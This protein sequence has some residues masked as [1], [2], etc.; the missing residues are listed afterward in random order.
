[1]SAIIAQRYPV[2][3]QKVEKNLSFDPYNEPAYH[4]VLS[5]MRREYE[6]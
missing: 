4:S 3:R 6:G 2:I 5:V 1:M